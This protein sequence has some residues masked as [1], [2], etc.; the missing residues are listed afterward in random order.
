MSTAQKYCLHP[1]Q[2]GSGYR[3][4]PHVTSHQKLII[5][6]QKKSLNNN[7]KPIRERVRMGNRE[8]KRE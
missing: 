4:M 1:H 6:K 7:K 5:M 3:R 8:K 2:P